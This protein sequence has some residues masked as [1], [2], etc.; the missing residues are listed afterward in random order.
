MTR[1]TAGDPEDAILAAVAADL[2]RIASEPSP[3]PSPGFADRVDAAI[4]RE[5]IPVPMA[6]A[7]S[8]VR[9]R[10]AFGFAAALRDSVRVGLG[11]NRPAAARAGAL[12]MLA[13][14][15]LIVASVGG[16]LAFGAASVLVPAP[17]ATHRSEPPATASPTLQPTPTGSSRPSPTASAGEPSHSPGPSGGDGHGPSASPREIPSP[18]ETLTPGETPRPS[19]TPRDT[20]SPTPSPTSQD[21]DG[22][23]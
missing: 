5:P 4:A 14:A 7:R 13:G 3:R 23:H 12:A 8:A 10:S 16:A 11:G 1:P 2:E 19:K 21:G 22:S 15:A 18:G 9:R 17:A 6:A 20:E